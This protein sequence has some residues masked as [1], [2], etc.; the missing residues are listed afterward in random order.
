MGFSEVD[1]KEALAAAGFAATLTLTLTL[2]LTLSFL[3]KRITETVI[4]CANNQR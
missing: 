3:S 2:A 1:A 4:D